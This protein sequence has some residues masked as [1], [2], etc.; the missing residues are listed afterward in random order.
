M[1]AAPPVFGSRF[2]KGTL[3]WEP[4]QARGLWVTIVVV[5]FAGK[6]RPCS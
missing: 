2:T 1:R 4:L 3:T 6:Q 5:G